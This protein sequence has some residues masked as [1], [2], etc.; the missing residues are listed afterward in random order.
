[1]GGREFP[2]GFVAH[3]QARVVQHG[4]DAAREQAVVRHQGHRHMP[5]VDALDHAGGGALGFVF[6]IAAGVQA[7]RADGH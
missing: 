6:R 3:R 4:A 7:W 5:G 1:M 2:A